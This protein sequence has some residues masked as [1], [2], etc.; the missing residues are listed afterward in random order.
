MRKILLMCPHQV[1]P[2]DESLNDPLCTINPYTQIETTAE[3]VGGSSQAFPLTGDHDKGPSP[4]QHTSTAYMTPFLPSTLYPPDD[5][6]LDLQPLEN[7]PN[8][9]IPN[10]ES[11]LDA[12]TDDLAG[13]KTSNRNETLIPL[14]LE[15]N[16]G[17]ISEEEEQEAAD[18]QVL[19]DNHGSTEVTIPEEEQLSL[20]EI[21]DL[22]F[23]YHPIS[24]TPELEAQSF[25]RNWHI[26]V[27]ST[28]HQT[29]CLQCE[30]PVIWAHVLAHVSHHRNQNYSALRA[31]GDVAP[32]PSKD[33]F[34]S[35]LIS[36]GADKP[37]PWPTQPIAPIDGLNHTPAARCNFPL[38]SFITHGKT[39]KLTR[40][41]IRRHTKDK[42]PM[43]L[44]SFT[45]ILTHHL[46][47]FR[48]SSAVQYVEIIPPKTLYDSNHSLQALIRHCA[49]RGLGATPDS[50][51]SDSQLKANAMNVIYS[52]LNWY[53]IIEDVSF[54]LV[55]QSASTPNMTSPVYESVI[56]SVGPQYY[57][58][59]V[60]ELDTLSVLT[61]RWLRSPNKKFVAQISPIPLH[62]LIKSFI[63]V[64]SSSKFPFGVPRKMVP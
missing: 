45:N 49:T 29:I 30:K 43:T 39:E 13:L 42:H 9:P 3:F 10:L 22:V 34:L 41:N 63:T 15:E 37:K 40:E 20:A 28:F 47:G 44:P 56:W 31:I 5:I 55:F 32:V 27:D 54:P 46:K 51:K 8:T 2:L 16:E 59:V 52:Q 1:G 11:Q 23:H 64:Q 62:A 60:E 38:C 7:L 36:L 4:L 26:I 58:A 53:K 21:D 24:E 48:G 6:M 17:C 35:R 50:F 33:D 19:D 14:E 18:I 25:L 61:R 57:A 12:L